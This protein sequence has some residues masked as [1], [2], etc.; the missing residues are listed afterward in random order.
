MKTLNLFTRNASERTV[1]AFASFEIA[2]EKMNY[3]RGGGEPIEGTSN[4]FPIW[5]EEPK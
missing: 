5:F 2:N 3:V 1:N 4:D